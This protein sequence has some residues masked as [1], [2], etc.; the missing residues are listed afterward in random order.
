MSFPIPSDLPLDGLRQL[1]EMTNLGNDD[2]ADDICLQ[3]KRAITATAEQ[4]I[5]VD[6][7]DASLDPDD[8]ELIAIRYLD[9]QNNW[10]SFS[11]RPDELRQLAASGRSNISDNRPTH[12]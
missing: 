12:G 10:V 11:F 2:R 4:A 5:F 1:L 3:L 7:N 6:I 9:I 8:P